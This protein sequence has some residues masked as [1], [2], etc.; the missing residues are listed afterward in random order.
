MIVRQRQYFE[1]KRRQQ[2]RP[3]LQ[4]QDNVA[5]GQASRDQEPRSLDVLN[6]N[7]LATSISHHNESA[8][9]AIPQMD[10]TLSDGSPTEAIRNITF[11]C[12]SNMKEAE[13]SLIDLVSFEGSTNKSTARPAREPHA[14]FSVKGLGHIKMET[15]PHSPK[16]IK[17]STLAM[18]KAKHVVRE[19]Q[20]FIS[21]DISHAFTQDSMNSINMFKEKRLSAKMDSALNE[22][23][24][25]RR[26]QFNCY[27]PDASENHNAD[28]YLD[29]EDLLYEPQAEKEW[30]S[31]HRRS[32]GNLADKDSDRLWRID[33]FDSDDHFPNQRQEHF[34]TSGYGFK[35]R[36]YPE[37][38]NSTRSCSGFKN[39]GIPSSRELFPD[40]SL[41]DNDEGTGLF[42]WEGCPPNKKIFNSNGAF[43]PSAWSFDTIDDSEKRRSPISEESCSSVAAMKK[44]SPS[45]KNEMNQKDEFHI[46]LDIPDMDG[47]FHGRS[48]FNNQ[49]KV[50]RKGTTDQKKLETELLEALSLFIARDNPGVDFKAPVHSRSKIR[51]VGDH[52][53]LKT[54]FQSPF[55]GEE[56]GIEKII[57]N[58]S[59][60]N[61]DV[62]YQLMLEQRVLRRLCVQKIVV[63]TPMKDKLNKDTR[64]VIVDDE[65]HALPKSV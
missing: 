45:T 10:C 34:D 3:E 11:L 14:S 32:D 27:F 9:G 30:Q 65:S 35:D 24:Y 7:N 4:S 42:E 59:P 20:T 13:I 6:I 23:D 29:D 43:G 55:I 41:M 50:D 51:D 63:P 17:R 57:A 22:S 26:K 48:L 37:R 1:Q 25:E 56:V 15:P 39:T 28:L 61:S 60:D 12:N 36:Y 62:Q 16:P 33:Q 52:S 46:N 40:H 64:F 58:L 54:M 2:Q 47:H 8:N 19:Q 49:E 21:F 44:P 5:G 38:R 31:K 18:P 53:K